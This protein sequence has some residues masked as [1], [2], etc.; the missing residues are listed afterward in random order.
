MT[1]GDD[2]FVVWDWEWTTDDEDADSD[3]EI[4]VIPET[5]PPPSSDESDEDEALS[6]AATALSICP[7]PVVKH[8]LTFKC[9]GSTKECR[10]Q[11]KLA[12]ISQLRNNG[13]EVP[14]II[15]PEPENQFDSKAIAFK[16]T[17]Y[18]VL[19][20]IHN[21]QYYLLELLQRHK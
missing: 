13:E 1:F 5:P 11:E 8:T 14:C 15:A 9:I 16:V 10:Y 21:K 3:N 20:N 4:T 2:V 7:T 19:I 6:K 17:V 12:R 18:S